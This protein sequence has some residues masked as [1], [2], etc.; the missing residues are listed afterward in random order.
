MPTIEKDAYFKYLENK[1]QSGYRAALLVKKPNDTYY[2]LLVASET[3]PTIFGTQDSFEFDLLNS[4]VK[5]KIEGKMSLDDKEV[6][7]LHH[8]DNV[9]RFEKLKDQTLD[10]LV[11]DSQFVGYKFVGTLSYRMND[12][13]ADVL[14]G[15]YT[16]TPMS[17]DPTP[18]LNARGL[19]QETLCF[20]SVVP[21]EVTAGEKIT[22]SV[23]QTNAVVTYTAFTIGNDGKEQTASSAI[24]SNTFTAPTAEGLYGITASADGYAPWTTTV[25]VKA[26]T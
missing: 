1:G 24:S 19:C 26:S 23:V 4:P 22:L 9:Y 20:G 3:V 13:T 8:R 14:R 25:F 16:I 2:S 18:I 17:A 11:I 21:D 7:V 12:A 15:T 10:F 6:E 5:G